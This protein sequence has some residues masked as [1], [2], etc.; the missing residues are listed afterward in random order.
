MSRRAN[1]SP[2]LLQGMRVNETGRGVTPGN[3]IHLKV[4]RKKQK[5]EMEEK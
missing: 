2:G 1:C 5:E 3:A 4:G